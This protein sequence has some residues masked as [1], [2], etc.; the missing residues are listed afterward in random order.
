MTTKEH[1]DNHLGPF[2]EWMTGDF[3]IR[4][5]EQQDFFEGNGIMPLQNKMAIDLGSGHGLQSIALAR[6]GFQVKSVDFNRLLLDHLRIRG[7]GLGIQVF[8]RDL[9]SGENFKEPAELIVCMGDT[10]A[11]LASPEEIR[12]LLDRCCGCLLNHGKLVL[13]YRDYGTEL[14]DANRFIPVKS[15]ENKIL[16][17]FLEYVED[18]VRVTDLLHERINGRW[19]QKASSYFKVRTTDQLMSQLLIETGFTIQKKEVINRMNYLVA[20]KI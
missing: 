13:S 1:Y 3:D 12:T 9:L 17:C 15:D 2:Y 18:R 5:K 19:T 14:R 6:L 7:D 16:T 4:Q 10:I 11:H 8:H 20:A